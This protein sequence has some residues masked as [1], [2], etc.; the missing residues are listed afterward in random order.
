MP[1]N[2]DVVE[3]VLLGFPKRTGGSLVGLA[4]GELLVMVSGWPRSG[5]GGMPNNPEPSMNSNRAII[6][7]HKI[8]S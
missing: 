1:N 5:M 7:L 8:R 3:V 6:N 4:S 2:P